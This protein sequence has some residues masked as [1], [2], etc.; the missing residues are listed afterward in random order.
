VLGHYSRDLKLFPLEEAVRRMTSLP[1]MRFGLA[2][3]GVLR[4]GAA[5]DIA[6]FDA[7]TVLDR[8]NFD[9]PARAAVGIDRVF[10]NGACV[11]ED[12]S[13]TGR[14]PGKCLALDA[15]ALDYAS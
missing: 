9:E 13:P 2:G 7:G 12:G 4:A 10:V 8:A 5:A 11:W 15:G 14:R 1:A 3:R 6:V